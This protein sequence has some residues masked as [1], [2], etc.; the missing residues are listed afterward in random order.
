M[1]QRYNLG[2][3]RCIFSPL[4]AGWLNQCPCMNVQVGRYIMTSFRPREL[5]DTLGLRTV[6]ERLGSLELIEALLRAK[7]RFSLV[8]KISRQ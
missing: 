1:A 5:F 2:P 3:R 8:I 6:R 7:H 4:V